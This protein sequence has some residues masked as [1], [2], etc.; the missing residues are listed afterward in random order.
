M[1]N[2]SNAPLLTEGRRQS[3]AALFPAICL[4]TTAYC[5]LPTHIATQPAD[6]PASVSRAGNQQTNGLTSTHSFFNSTQCV[7]AR[8]TR[9]LGN[10]SAIIAP[11]KT[12]PRSLSD[13]SSL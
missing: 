9:L 6:Q 1:G 11:F 3:R 10:D 12:S 5:L 8:L 7:S 4:P 2:P 13:S